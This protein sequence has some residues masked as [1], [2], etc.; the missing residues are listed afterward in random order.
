[1]MPPLATPSGTLAELPA[2]W[3]SMDEMGDWRL[4]TFYNVV[5]GLDELEVVEYLGG[6]F[7]RSIGG[8]NLSDQRILR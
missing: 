3:P 7:S 2:R 1:M 6:T 8:K 4:P 5:N